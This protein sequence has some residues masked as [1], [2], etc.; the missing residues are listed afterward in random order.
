V[1]SDRLSAAAISRG[2][3]QRELPGLM[4]SI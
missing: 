4:F 2:Q 3:G 1:L